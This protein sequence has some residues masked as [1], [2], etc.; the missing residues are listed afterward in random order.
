M[1][2]TGGSDYENL[3]S[4]RERIPLQARTQGVAVT[5]RD[6]EDLA[7]MVAGVGKAKAEYN[8]GRKVSL[9]IYPSDSSVLG[10]LQASNIL[11]NNIRS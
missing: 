5:K 3:E 2:I 8:C 7:M 4:M 1:I 11:R 10:D 9:Y 6:Y